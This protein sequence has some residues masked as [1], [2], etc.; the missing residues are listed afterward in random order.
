MQKAIILPGHK[1][2]DR[3]I[4]IPNT[5]SDG[6]ATYAAVMGS[7]DETGHFIAL[8]TRYKP[9]IGDSVVGLVTD[10]RGPG[11]ALD[12]NTPSSAFVHSKFLRVRLDIGN[13]I[14]GKV[15]AVTE[16][17]EVDL[18]DI[19]QLP[20]GEIIRVP[21]AKV[22]RIIGRKNSMVD[23]IKN[24]TGGEIFI[25]NNGYVWISEKNNIPLAIKAIEMIIK[26]AHTSGL[27]DAMQA[28]LESEKIK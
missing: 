15:M 13:V 28:F 27:T 1:L 17:G 16:I 18:E 3:N 6:Q 8:E 23:L 11:Y 25:G 9:C 10:A 24:Y 14:V 26:K 22:P 19:I 5:Y 20:K 21:P 2:A 12:L 4:S 7:L